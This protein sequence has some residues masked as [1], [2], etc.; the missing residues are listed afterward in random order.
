MLLSIPLRHLL[1]TPKVLLKS[2]VHDKLLTNGVARQF[3]GKLILEAGLLVGIRGLDNAVVERLQ[4][5]V[6]VAD[7]VADAHFGRCVGPVAV[8]A[9]RAC[10]TAARDARLTDCCVG[11]VFLRGDGHGAEAETEHVF[12]LVTS[13]LDVVLCN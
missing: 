13:G 1:P 7:R 8:V 9:H 12:F 5:A 10:G 2:R 6:V 11:D 3:P 4:L